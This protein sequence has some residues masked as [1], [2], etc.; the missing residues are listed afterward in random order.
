MSEQHSSKQLPLAIWLPDGASFDNYLAGPNAQLVDLLA[1]PA[2]HPESQFTFLWGAS[3]VG[4]SHLLQA[5]CHQMAGQ[6]SVYL[7][8]KQAAEFAP[9]MLEGMEQLSLVVIDDLDAIAGDAD[10]ELALFNLYNRMRD[11]ATA[12]LL[13]SAEQPL[14]SLGLKLP[15]LQSRLAWGGVYQL[16]PLTDQE[17]LIALQQRAH[18]RGF[19]LS[20]DVGN[21]LLRHYQRNLADLFVLL[22]RLDRVSLA[23]QRRL[24]VPFVKSVI[25]ESVD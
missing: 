19:E 12:R 2:Q 17:K 24:T 20:D 25:A 21:Y 1:N 23:E 9:E 7:P 15:D 8:M 16:Q 13:V 11:L 22:E 18:N 4:K 3:G 14:A 6:G 5:A 10:W